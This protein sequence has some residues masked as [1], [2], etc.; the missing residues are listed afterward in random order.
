[1]LAPP[2]ADAVLAELLEPVADPAAAPGAASRATSPAAVAL[3]GDPSG[4]LAIVAVTPDV[5]SVFGDE[6]LT[7]TLAGWTDA[8]PLPAVIVGG[9]PLIGLH[10]TAHDTVQGMLMTNAA[11]LEDVVVQGA[12][13]CVVKPGALARLPPQ[14]RLV[15]EP[16]LPRELT[17]RGRPGDRYQIFVAPALRETPEWTLRGANRLDPATTTSL[18]QVLVADA[19][20]VARLA[21]P[22]L[23]PGRA[24]VQALAS[25]RGEPQGSTVAARWTP[26]AEI[27]IRP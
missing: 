10:A 8:E 21:V 25:P 4:G 22:Q 1:M 5:A 26:V 17:I 24:F 6:P 15:A 27:E 19:E 2:I 9:A 16:G 12:R 7:I 20:G 18:P 11:G 13:G 14:I 3:A 23:S